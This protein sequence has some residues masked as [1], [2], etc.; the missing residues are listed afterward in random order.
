MD[1]SKEPETTQAPVPAKETSKPP[2]DPERYAELMRRLE[3]ARAAKA[4]KKAENDE[5]KKGL[6]PTSVR[7]PV[8]EKNGN[9][10]EGEGEEE[11]KVLLIE[12]QS[13]PPKTVPPAPKKPAP[14]K[15][16]SVSVPA[17]A[18]AKREPEP[19]EDVSEEESS[20]ESDDEIEQKTNPKSKKKTREL[21]KEELKTKYRERYAAKYESILRGIRERE[22]AEIAA[23]NATK[24]PEPP[25][26]ARERI[27][28][29]NATLARN[30][31]RTALSE[32]VMR[33]TMRGLFGR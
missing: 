15:R 10:G 4:R 22:A 33:N 21:S 29:A 28:V 26:T 5:I 3:L 16:V 20:S 13:Q 25:M 27:R 19:E 32:E 9:E 6:K 30:T 1:E 31:I 8:P 24:D 2:V 17:P 11:E 12:T 18:P 7:E 23:R 14:K